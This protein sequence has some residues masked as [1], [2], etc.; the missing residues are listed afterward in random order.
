MLC[1][2][3]GL[4]G[5]QSRAPEDGVHR[6]ILGSGGS[7]PLKYWPRGMASPG[8]HEAWGRGPH[9]PL[10]FNIAITPGVGSLGLLEGSGEGLLAILP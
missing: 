1:S 5:T 2:G 8:P 3:G 6:A 7:L 10:P 4:P 9:G